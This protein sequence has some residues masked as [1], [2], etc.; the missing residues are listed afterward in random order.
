MIFDFKQLVN[1][2]DKPQIANTKEGD[3]SYSVRSALCKET[4]EIGF[5]LWLIFA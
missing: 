4:S 1:M 3:V 5:I 2:T